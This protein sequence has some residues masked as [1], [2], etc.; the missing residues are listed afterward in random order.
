LGKDRWEGGD[1]V[2]SEACEDCSID[3][4]GPNSVQG[5]ADDGTIAVPNVDNLFRHWYLRDFAFA[6]HLDD[7]VDLVHLSRVLD[8]DKGVGMIGVTITQTVDS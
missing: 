4:V 3:I 2:A 7:A 1:E 8:V 6:N 5:V